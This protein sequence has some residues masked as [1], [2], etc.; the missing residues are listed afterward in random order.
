MGNVGPMELILLGLLAVIIFGPA[1]LPE[2]GRKIGEGLRE[3]KESVSGHTD[4]A[5]VVSVVNE[6]RT[7]ASP[8]NLASA[9]IPGVRDVQETV[10]AAKGTVSGEAATTKAGEA[11]AGKPAAA[12]PA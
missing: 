8:A 3:F 6:V 7:A 9:F 12:P 11:A 1:K 10:G 2:M 4:L 5:E